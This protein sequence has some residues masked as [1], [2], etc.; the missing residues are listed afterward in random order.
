MINQFD[1]SR[2]PG[3]PRQVFRIRISSR[4]GTGICYYVTFVPAGSVLT[5][6]KDTYPK[7][8]YIEKV[9]SKLTK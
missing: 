1:I 2:R 4:L 5:S 6:T 7:W 9:Y 8:L 3:D